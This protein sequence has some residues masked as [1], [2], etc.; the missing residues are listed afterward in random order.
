MRWTRPLVGKGGESNIVHQSQSFSASI[1]PTLPWGHPEKYKAAFDSNL[2]RVCQPCLAH[3]ADGIHWSDYNEGKP[4]TGRAA[5][6]FDQLL[7]DPIVKKYRLTCRTDMRG[8]G[9]SR[10]YRSVRI[11]LH[12]RGNDLK[13]HP[14]AWKTVAD[15]IVVDDPRKEKNPWGNPRLQFNW[16]TCWIHEGVY[17]APM[18]VY[19][20]DRSD[21]FEGFDYRTRHEEDVLDF[22]IGTSRDG[23]N[24]DKSWVHARKPL[25]PRGPTGSFDKDGVFPPSQ[26]VT[27]ADEHWIYYGGA[28]ERHY[29]IGRDM[30][31]GLAKLRL[32]G[33]IGMAAKNGPGTLVTRPFRLDGE[34]LEL[35]VDAGAGRVKV[36]I[37]DREGKPMA[38]FCG[39]NAATSEAVDDV[40]FRP[41]WSGKNGLSTLRGRVVRLRFELRKATLYAFQVR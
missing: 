37:L 26:F 23:V 22:Y 2:D 8:Q 10:E 5:D 24:F 15:R 39:A 38:D 13:N 18:N 31:I 3:S 32:D 19:T 17:F 20:M 7:W 21:F 1:D 4:V 34:T 9:G 12:D 40:R 16:M 29:S 35:N 30:K 6:F 25:V 33:F 14:T 36:E 11:M 28:S 27:R 41:R